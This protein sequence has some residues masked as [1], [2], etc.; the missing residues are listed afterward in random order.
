MHGLLRGLFEQN[1]AAAL[2]ALC[3][4]SSLTE[5][6]EMNQVVLLEERPE[7]STEFLCRQNA[8]VWSQFGPIEFDV[9]KGRKVWIDQRTRGVF[10]EVYRD[11]RL[12]FF[13]ERERQRPPRSPCW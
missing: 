4:S 12:C 11:F 8:S 13:Q 3:R 6:F 10:E 1:R 5:L 7:F 2:A 9:L